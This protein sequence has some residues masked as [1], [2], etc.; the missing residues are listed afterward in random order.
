MS[1]G[2]DQQPHLTYDGRAFALDVIFVPNSK[3]DKKGEFLCQEVR[4]LLK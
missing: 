3:Q 1:H 2:R 4:T